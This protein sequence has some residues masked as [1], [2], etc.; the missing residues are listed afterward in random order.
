MRGGVTLR[1]FT[2]ESLADERILAL[3]RK[4]TFELA[5]RPHWKAAVGGAILAMLK[6][7]GKIEIDIPEALGSPFR[8]VGEEALLAKFLDCVRY[9][10][11]HISPEAAAK[12]A[13]GILRLEHIAD[14]GG[15]LG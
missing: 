5:P 7:G 3:A 13:D 8:P 12:L 1:D 11:A 4:S 10:A 2:L 14:V 9:G 15:L 6:D